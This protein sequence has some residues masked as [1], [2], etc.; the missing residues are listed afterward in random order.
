MR[1]RSGAR[2]KRRGQA[3]AEFALVAPVFMLMLGG[4][5]QFGIFFWDQNT[6][7]QVVRDAGRFAATVGDCSANGN[8]LI[9]NKTS[10]IEGQTPFSGAYGGIT[11][12]LPAAG[13]DPT[14]PPTSNAQVVWVT[15]Q[16]N[17]TVPVFFPLVNGAI[18]STATFRMEPQTK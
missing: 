14:C 17:A 6:L 4:T 3:L 13:S 5:I 8:T 11:V 9:V 12:T 7:N 18:S 10:A 2:R 1:E 15:I 16:A